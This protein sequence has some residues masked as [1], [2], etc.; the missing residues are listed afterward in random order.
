MREL[1]NEEVK[2]IAGGNPAAGMIQIAGSYFLGKTVGQAAYDA[3]TE[4][5]GSSLGEQIYWATN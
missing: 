5:T 1:T 2:D 3:Y 4:A